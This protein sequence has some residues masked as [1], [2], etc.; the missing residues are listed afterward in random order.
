MPM[1]ESLGA[2]NADPAAVRLVVSDVINGIL[3]ET[4]RATR[5]IADDDALVATIGLDSLDLAVMTVRL[6][7]QFGNDPFRQRPR[8][9]RTFGELLAVYEQSLRGEM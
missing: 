8:V 5:V 1:A 3:A 2:A 9:V 4:S 6:E 7:Q